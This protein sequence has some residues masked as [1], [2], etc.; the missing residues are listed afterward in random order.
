MAFVGKKKRT[1]IQINS[2]DLAGDQEY[3][4]NDVELE[5]LS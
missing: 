5:S 4:K 2:R 3:R 1:F